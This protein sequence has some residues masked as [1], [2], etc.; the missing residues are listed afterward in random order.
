MIYNREY[1][2]LLVR[3]LDNCMY[4]RKSVS[5][6]QISS[7]VRYE[8]DEDAYKIDGTTVLEDEPSTC[9]VMAIAEIAETD[10]LEQPPLNAVIDPDALDE[11]FHGGV[12]SEG[13]DMDKV[14]F[15]YHGYRVTLHRDG[16]MIIQPRQP[17]GSKSQIGNTS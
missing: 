15:N 1:Y 13:S 9:L 16:D 7:C 17:S 4:S 14:S 6:D 8:R 2:I 5:K 10:P 3:V 12:S 11:L